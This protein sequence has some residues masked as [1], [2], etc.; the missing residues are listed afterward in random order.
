MTNRS[1][2][3]QNLKEQRPLATSVATSPFKDNAPQIVMAMEKIVMEGTFEE[4]VSTT[5]P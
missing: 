1:K 2:R 3:V 4:N 5:Q